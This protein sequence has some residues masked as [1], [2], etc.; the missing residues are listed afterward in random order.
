MK[1]KSFNYLKGSVNFCRGSVKKG[2]KKQSLDCGKTAINEEKGKNK[3]V[4]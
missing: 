3:K 4:K 2:G 1:S